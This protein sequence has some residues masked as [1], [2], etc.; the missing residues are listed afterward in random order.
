MVRTHEIHCFEGG[1]TKLLN[2]PVLSYQYVY[3]GF[4]MCKRI[5]GITNPK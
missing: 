5:S 3:S 4:F 1:G 2:E